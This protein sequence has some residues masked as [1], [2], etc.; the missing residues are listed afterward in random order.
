MSR[1]R[2]DPNGDD[3][4]ALDVTLLFTPPAGGQ[5]TAV[6]LTAGDCETA[7]S[8]GKLDACRAQLPA[9]DVVCRHAET[10]GAP[11][12]LEKPRT[13]PRNLRFRFPDTD[14]RVGSETDD[15]TLTGPVMIAVDYEQAPGGPSMMTR[16]TVQIPKEGVVVNVESFDF[17]RVAGPTVQ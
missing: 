16:M 12:D 5:R 6:L 14:D 8:Q 3:V 9:G 4:D 1:R 13:R 10:T 15:L 7:E 17:V 11:V 2:H